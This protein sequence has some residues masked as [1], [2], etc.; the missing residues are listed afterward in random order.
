MK[1]CQQC[2][3]PFEPGHNKQQYCSVECRSIAGASRTRDKRRKRCATSGCKNPVSINM[4]TPYCESC[5]LSGK[6]IAK[7]LRK[8]KRLTNG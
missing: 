3:G 7:D 4:E 5:F 2:S 8:M 6:V 1:E